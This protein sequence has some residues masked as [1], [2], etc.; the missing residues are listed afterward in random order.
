[1]TTE[2]KALLQH[3]EW[4]IAEIAYALGFECPTYFNNHFKKNTGAIPKSFRTK[5]A[6][7]V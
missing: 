3:T 7:S 6:Q 2:A 5:E 4:S 1:M